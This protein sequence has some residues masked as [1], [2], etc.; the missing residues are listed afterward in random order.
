MHF[1]S[2]MTYYLKALATLPVLR[3]SYPVTLV[4]DSHNSYQTNS[5]ADKKKKNL[6][7]KLENFYRGWHPIPPL[8]PLF[9][10]DSQWLIATPRG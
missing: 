7:K 9:L 3:T 8:L 1:H 2:K 10:L 4:T 5:S 6:F